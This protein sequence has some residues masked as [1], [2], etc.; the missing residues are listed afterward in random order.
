MKYEEG[1]VIV[2]GSNTNKQFAIGTEREHF[3]IL[4]GEVISCISQD[5][6]LNSKPELNRIL[7]HINNKYGVDLSFIN[8]K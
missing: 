5:I 2:I 8:F 7:N 1:E 4:D 3:E 6:N